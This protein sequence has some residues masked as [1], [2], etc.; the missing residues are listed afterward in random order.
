[1]DLPNRLRKYDCV[2]VG[3]VAVVLRIS[4][5]IVVKYPRSIQDERFKRE[6]EFYRL[7]DSQEP[8]PDI[9][10]CF[11][12]L[13]NA[14]FL[15]YCSANNLHERFLSRQIREP[16]EEYP[17]RVTSVTVKDDIGTV[18][19]WLQQLVSAAAFLEK[20]CIAHNDLHPRNLLLDQYLNLKLSDFDSSGKIGQDFPGAPAPYARVLNHGLNKGGFGRCG[21]RT[22]QFAIG[23]ILYS[24]LYGYEPYEDT[25]LDGDEIINRFQDMRFPELGEDVLEK[26]VQKC[27]FEQFQSMS[28]LKS[29]VLASTSDIATK[30]EV[31]QVESAKEKETCKELLRSGLF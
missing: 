8:C 21:A 4:H 17:G 2:G 15:S 7:L 19:R 3:A 9:V 24:M 14:I 11:L 20:L 13:P 26:I 18:G 30:M 1:M 12:V 22:E 28:A 27:W 6:V 29:E 31:S 25:Y 23:S 10:E 5:E 16:T